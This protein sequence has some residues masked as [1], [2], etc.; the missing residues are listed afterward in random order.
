MSKMRIVQRARIQNGQ[1][2][3][4]SPLDLP[5]GTEVTVTIEAVEGVCPEP[6]EPIECSSPPCFAAWVDREE[7]AG[8]A[9]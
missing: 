5:D 6:E 8:G 9:G 3:L 4:S 7:T 1:I 2:V